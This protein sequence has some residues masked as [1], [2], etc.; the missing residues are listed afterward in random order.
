MNTRILLYNLL[1]L[2]AY[3]VLIHVS[4]RAAGGEE[5]ALAIM[6]WSLIALAVHGGVLLVLCI[7]AFASKRKEQAL[8]YLL[9]A[10]AVGT[11][12]FGLCW[13]SAMVAG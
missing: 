13:G 9:A 8:S 1:G 4:S 6:I 3:S 10:A 2:F 7:V 12:G 5:A 11:I